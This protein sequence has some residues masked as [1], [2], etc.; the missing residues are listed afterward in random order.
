MFGS[1]W[2]QA[3]NKFAE[4]SVRIQPEQKVVDVG[5]YSVVRHPFYFAAFFMFGGI[6]LALGSLRALIPAA[7]AIS[8]LVVRTALE[9]RMLRRELQGYKEY[10]GRVRYR[11]VPGLW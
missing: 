3:V 2:A 6:P 7:V 10:A 1:T 4:R 9:D 11:L 5:P 8:I